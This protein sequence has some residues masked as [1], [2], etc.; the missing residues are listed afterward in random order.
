VRT[1]HHWYLDPIYPPLAMLAAA[2]AFYLLERTAPGRGRA[3][4]LI[5]LVALPLALC[6][7]RVLTR[8][9]IGDP[10]PADQR[11]LV[12]LKSTS[13]SVCR[14]VRVTCRLEHSERFL[15]EVVDGFEVVEP[16]SALPAATRSLEAA[17]LLVGKSAWRRPPAPPA[18]RLPAGDRL[19]MASP[20]FALYRGAD[21]RAPPLP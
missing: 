4:A 8:A 15:L 12:A 6:E 7:G 21:V 3:A 19:L 14:E 1:Q 13:G 20:S 11:F 2:S 10:M 5:G 18:D 9:L 17:C 16:G